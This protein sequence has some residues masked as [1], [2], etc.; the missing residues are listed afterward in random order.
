MSDASEARFIEIAAPTVDE[1][2]QQGLQELGLTRAEVTVELLDEGARGILGIGGRMA[3]IRLTESSPSAQQ[4]ASQ[5]SA[6]Q[7]QAASPARTD[8]ASLDDEARVAEYISHAFHRAQ[9]GRPGPVVLAL[10]EDMLC[11]RTAPGTLEPATEVQAH[12]A[13]DKCFVRFTFIVDGKFH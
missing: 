6:H 13:E 10:P 2:I 1:G 12:P 11:A 8:P 5:P 4:L 3:R 9:A 7:P